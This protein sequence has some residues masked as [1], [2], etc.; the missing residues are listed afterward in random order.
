V[1]PSGQG[2]ATPS[3]PANASELQASSSTVVQQQVESFNTIISEEAAGAAA[4]L[5]DAGS[6]KQ[7]A[8]EVVVRHGAG[9]RVV[10][11]AGMADPHADAAATDGTTRAAASASASGAAEPAE[12]QQQQK[13]ALLRQDFASKLKVRR[14]LGPVSM[15]LACSQH[16]AVD[17]LG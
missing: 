3:K 13:L 17:L 8:G 12:Q 6:S 5:A 14:D 4:L 1:S 15:L 11:P 7:E 10:R 9:F 2:Q 16:V